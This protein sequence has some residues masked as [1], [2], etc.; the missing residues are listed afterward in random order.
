MAGR[1]FASGY[2]EDILFG[3]GQVLHGKGKGIY[4]YDF[5]EATGAL[6]EVAVTGNVRNPSFM[7]ADPSGQYLYAVN[8]FKEF[9]GLA[10]GAVSAFRIEA[11]GHVGFLNQK[12]SH[13]TDPCHLIVDKTGRNVLVANFASGSVS[14]FPRHADGSLADASCV[15]QHTGSSVD[16]VRQAGPHAHAVALSHDNR[17]AFVPELG[18]DTIEI[19]V[20]D[21]ENGKITPNPDQP[22]IRA[23]PGAGPRQL[24]MHPK[25][26]FA[27]VINELNSTMTAYGYDPARG[28]LTEIGTLSTL[29]GDFTG[30]S[31]CA[32]VQISPDGRFVYGSNRGHNSIAIFRVSEADGSLALVGHEPTRGEIPRHFDISPDGGF[33]CVANQDTGNLAVF[34]R[35]PE[36]GHLSYTGHEIAD[37]GTPVCVRFL[38]S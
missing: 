37:A 26:D 10:S 23:A 8:E 24:T 7:A 11:D 27:Y 21:A 32:E 20:L 19:Y 25:R 38:S 18:G 5:D 33:I 35:D 6:S 31:F 13:G 22:R 9:E 16:P 1:V 14:V 29:P 30:T 28:V 4:A 12:P 17:F 2:S 3:T 36:T 15:V 34:R